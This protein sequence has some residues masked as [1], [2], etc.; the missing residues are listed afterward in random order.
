VHL[1]GSRHAWL[2]LQPT[3]SQ[4]L[5]AVVDDA[6]KHLLYAQFVEAARVPR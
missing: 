6:T 1:D 2:A 4:T 5:L 3:A